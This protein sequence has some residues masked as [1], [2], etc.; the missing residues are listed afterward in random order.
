MSGL[1]SLLIKSNDMQIKNKNNYSEVNNKNDMENVNNTKI[2][3][4]NLY[5]LYENI[6]SKADG[7][8]VLNC[9]MS[10]EIEDYF[11]KNNIKIECEFKDSF[12][13]DNKRAYA[14][15]FENKKCFTNPQREMLI[16]N[17]SWLDYI[18]IVFCSS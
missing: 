17:Q 6:N 7:I 16:E 9:D 14:V 1:S 3:G 18:L 4:K 13:R 5:R 10:Q 12:T 11:G 8:I 2:F 15:C